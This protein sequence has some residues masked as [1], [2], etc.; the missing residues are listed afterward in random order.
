MVKKLIIWDFDGVVADTESIWLNTRMELLNKYFNLN[1][2]FEKTNKLLGGM[3]EKTKKQVL[4]SMGIFTTDAF[5]QE[6][7]AMD[8]EFVKNNGFEI[9]KDI[10]N[11]FIDKKFVQCIA[12]GGTKTK[13]GLKINVAKIE[14]WFDINKNVFT[15]DMV[16]NGKPEPDLFLL[17]AKTMGYN[18]QECIIVEDSIAGMTAAIN[19]KIDVIAFIGAKMYQSPDYL[20][21]VKSLGI[22]NIFYNMKDVKTYLDKI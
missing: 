15:A 6:A 13:T 19:A 2:D 10:N 3:S 5:W 9:T 16:E 21:E 12:T 11:I 14:E 17:A 1:Y 7:V 8:S 20:E 22:E 4:D 18:P